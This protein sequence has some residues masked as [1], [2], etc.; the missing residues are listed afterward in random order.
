MIKKVLFITLLSISFIGYSLPPELQAREG[1][2]PLRILC[3]IL[4]VYVFTLNVVGQVPDVEVKLLLPPHQGCPHNYDLT[5]GDLKN[6]SRADV[7]VANGLGMESF[8]NNFVKEKKGKISFIEGAAKIE[9][10]REAPQPSRLRKTQEKTGHDHAGEINGHA[11]VSPDK[12]AVMVKTIAEGLAGR[13]PER[14]HEFLEN[15]RQY[16]RK[17]EGLGKELKEVV[18]KAA[19]K[20]IIAFHDIL[21]YLARDTGLQVVAIIES[22]LGVEPSSR[23]LVRLIQTGRKE[24]AAAILSEPPYSDKLVRSISQETGIPWFPFDPVATGKPAADTYERIMKKNIE[25]LQKAL[26]GGRVGL[27]GKVLG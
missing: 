21:D 9:P 24:K 25:I 7:I 5:P 23:D 26:N 1:R 10:I 15:G 11:W 19:N 20:K 12:A 8:L 2:K 14:S 16:A 22:Q 6:L 18:S 13:D 27:D 17:L 3:T 4:P